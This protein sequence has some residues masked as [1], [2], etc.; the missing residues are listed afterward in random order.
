MISSEMPLSTAIAVRASIISLFLA[1]GLPQDADVPAHDRLL[2]FRPLALE[3]LA[4]PLPGFEP[5]PG[6]GAGPHSKTVLHATM[7]AYAIRALVGFA[8]EREVD[9][10][11]VGAGD[12]SAVAHGL[13]VAEVL[14]RD[15][16]SD[17]VRGSARVGAASVRDQGC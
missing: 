12:G 14:H 8:L 7:S 17:G 10:V 5:R 16:R 11:V 4:L 15:E 2:S 3:R 9:A 6:R 13:A 1:I